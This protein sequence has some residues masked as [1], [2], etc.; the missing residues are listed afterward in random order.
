MV[1]EQ[2]ST[3]LSPEEWKQLCVLNC[4]QLLNFLNACPAMGKMEGSE[5]IVSGMTS[6]RIAEIDAHVAR[7]RQFLMAWARSKPV[8]IPEPVKQEAAPEANG[9]APP[10]KKRGRPRKAEAQQAAQH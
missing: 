1:T 4:Q 6:A 3:Q 9:A 7:S 10:V 2:K 5:D 8:G